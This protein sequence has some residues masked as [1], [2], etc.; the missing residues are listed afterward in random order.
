M[1]RF[2]Q[3]FMCWTF[4]VSILMAVSGFA[5]AAVLAYKNWSKLLWIPLVYF[6]LMESLQVFNYLT[7]GSCS[8]SDQMLTFLSYLHI[9]FQPFF[10]NAVMLYFVPEDFR[11]KIAVWVFAFCFASSILMLIKLYPFDWAGT[12]S[13]G[14]MLCGPKLCSIP[15]TFHFGWQIPFNNIDLGW[16]DWSYVFAAFILP[17]LYGA[18]KSNLYNIFFGPFLAYLLTNNP[19]EFPAVWCLL[20]VGYVILALLPFIRKRLHVK[21]WYF[22]NY[23]K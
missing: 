11:K 21:K 1:R 12:C 18:W 6:A 20:S 7:L 13:S 8:P 19:N 22:W 16:F 10:V 2:F 17:F 14:S 23:P 15:S 9:V 3:I 5:V 4:E